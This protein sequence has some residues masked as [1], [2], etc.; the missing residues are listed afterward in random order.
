MNPTDK[1]IRDH[2]QAHG[3]LVT[4]SGVAAVRGALERWWGN[5]TPVAAQAQPCE[6][7]GQVDEGQTGEFPCAQCGLSVAHDE[8]P[9]I[10]ADGL[11][12][13]PWEIEEIAEFMAMEMAEIDGHEGDDK[14]RLIWEGSPPEPW[15]EVWQKY[16]P[17]AER[18]LSAGLVMVK[19]RA[20]DA[21]ANPQPS[22]NAGVLDQVVDRQIAAAYQA[23]MDGDEF[24]VLAAKRKIGR[25]AQAQ[26]P[27]SQPTLNGTSIAG[28]T[29][30]NVPGFEQIG[31]ALEAA[32]TTSGQ[33]P[34]TWNTFDAMVWAWQAALAQQASGQDR[35]HAAIGNAFLVVLRDPA[36]SW[37]QTESWDF[38]TR[39]A[40]ESGG[41][42][43]DPAAIDAARKAKGVV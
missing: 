37:R 22:G 21:S 12:L 24:D 33:Q 41:L 4:E 28:D 9:V 3:A 35:V 42:I 36:V 32:I 5:F 30:R 6:K 8:Q 39:V 7:C 17:N 20:K 31:A 19:E 1:E 11:P 15:G 43:D 16:I 34:H 38:I 26:P 27:V 29:I 2:L 25:A 18:L 23:G 14:H 10:V 40:E 13:A